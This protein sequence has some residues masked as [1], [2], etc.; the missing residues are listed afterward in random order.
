MA[1]RTIPDEASIYRALR[2][3]WLDEGRLTYRAFLL[4]PSEGGL[5]VSEI[6]AN[7]EAALRSCR[8][9]ASLISGSVRAACDD[10]GAAFG[11]D[12]VPMEHPADPGYAWIIGLPVYSDE[13]EAA[14]EQANEAADAL[15]RI[16]LHSA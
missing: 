5:S 8:G 4:R 12:V 16:A 9:S 11:L 10:S 13:G 7:A 14:R 3:G 2:P 6:R 1:E 15:L